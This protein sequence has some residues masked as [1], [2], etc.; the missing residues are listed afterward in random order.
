MQ[1]KGAGWPEPRAQ[2]D[3][4]GLR[5]SILTLNHCKP[6]LDHFTDPLLPPSSSRSTCNHV[7]H[8]NTGT[9]QQHFSGHHVR[10]PDRRALPGRVSRPFPGLNPRGVCQ[11]SGVSISR[12]TATMSADAA[13]IQERQGPL[14]HCWQVQCCGPRTGGR[15]PVSSWPSREEASPGDAAGCREDSVTEPPAYETREIPRGLQEAV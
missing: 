1:L 14:G 6:I 8:R 3:E 7:G 12:C 2:F 11:D 9:C 15:G 5:Y 10:V 13:E 4:F